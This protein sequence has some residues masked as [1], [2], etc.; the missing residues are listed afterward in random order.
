MTSIRKA[1]DTRRWLGRARLAVAFVVLVSLL[2][3][4]YVAVAQDADDCCDMSFETH[5]DV[6]ESY[7]DDF[8]DYDAN[9]MHGDGN[10]QAAEHGGSDAA[11]PAANEGLSQAVQ[12][13]LG[14]NG[15]LDVAFQ[16]TAPAVVGLSVRAGVLALT[17]NTALADLAGGIAAAV[18]AYYAQQIYEAWNNLN[19]ELFNALHRAMR[20]D[21][22]RQIDIDHSPHT[23]TEDRN[24]DDD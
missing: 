5:A 17:R 16:V 23:P 15:M 11:G 21:I 19:M 4:Q 9:S 3:L 24:P 22:Q 8:G 18:T 10:E 13:N 14:Q 2:S 12:Q 20:R 6:G 1:L 7:S